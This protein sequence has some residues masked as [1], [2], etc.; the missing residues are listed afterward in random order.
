MTG[1]A[2]DLEEDAPSGLRTIENTRYDAAFFDIRMPG[3]G[4]IHLLRQALAIQPQLPIIVM[5]GHGVAETR[6]EALQAGAFSFLYKPFRLQEVND[7]IQ[8]VNH[9]NEAD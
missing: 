4:G 5:S 9:T 6:R 2:T 8:R 3:M 7:I 1:H